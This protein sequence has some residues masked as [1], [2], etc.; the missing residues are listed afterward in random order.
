[1][2]VVSKPAT[3]A[4]LMALLEDLNIKLLHINC[5]GSEDGKL[6]W[7]G[8]NSIGMEEELTVEQFRSI[9]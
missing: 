2:K 4:N 9:L 3:R 1:M 6:Q 8:E 5:H 7:E